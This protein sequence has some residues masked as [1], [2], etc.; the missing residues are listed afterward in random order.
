MVS[1][2]DRRQ[3]LIYKV[4]A[5]LLRETDMEEIQKNART[6]HRLFV[7]VCGLI[8]AVGLQDPDR[9]SSNGALDELKF[10]D[11]VNWDAYSKHLE[12]TAGNGELRTPTQPASPIELQ[13]ARA[14]VDKIPGLENPSVFAPMKVLGVDKAGIKN[15]ADS[16]KIGDYD[17]FLRSNEGAHLLEYSAKQLYPDRIIAALK[18]LGSASQA[19]KSSKGVALPS[20]FVFR[21]DDYAAREAGADG[22]D[23]WSV[24]VSVSAQLHPPGGEAMEQ[25]LP[26]DIHGLRLSSTGEYAS[27]TRVQEWLSSHY[28]NSDQFLGKDGLLPK[29]REKWS[30]VKDLTLP[31]ALAK[32]AKEQQTK[33][34]AD[35]RE[36]VALLNIPI[37]RSALPLVGPIVCLALLLYLL[38]N[39]AWLKSEMST[40]TEVLWLPLR[41]GASNLAYGV[42]VCTLTI[43]PAIALFM[44]WK[45]SYELHA[46]IADVSNSGAM[47]FLRNEQHWLGV[48][49]SICVPI[50]GFRIAWRLART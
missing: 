1:V 49:L 4:V 33:S 37:L 40:N 24:D 8:F 3:G 32:L 39:V 41:P 2:L 42:T 5:L 46:L 31:E 21:V 11:S 20:R 14:L 23:A 44:L 6:L 16:G 27:G 36:S 22:V 38:A 17:V 43:L 30:E 34:E 12:R 9:R 25:L 19:Y 47:E 26:G 15:L 48:L 50:V 10:L 18:S 28:A 29:L 13:T 45:R 7:L 35:D